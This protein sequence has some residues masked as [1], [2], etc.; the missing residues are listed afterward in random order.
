MTASGRK[1]KELN[2]AVHLVAGKPDFGAPMS[3]CSLSGRKSEM[4]ALRV[5]ARRLLGANGVRL[6]ACTDRLWGSSSP[7]RT[8]RPNRRLGCPGGSRHARRPAG[9]CR[10]GL[11]KG[12]GGRAPPSGALEQSWNGSS[13]ARKLPRSASSARPGACP[14]PES[15]HALVLQRF[16]PAPAPPR[17]GGARR[18]QPRGR[19]QPAGR[20]C[21]VRPRSGGGESRPPRYRLRLRR[22][23]PR[24]RPRKA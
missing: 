14:Q 21:L 13:D 15:L 11:P 24:G 20:E 18:P 22:A 6:P 17:K 9:Q 12:G 23:R 2:G 4:P 19:A 16:L 7:R 3:R 5:G 10:V 8:R 1:R